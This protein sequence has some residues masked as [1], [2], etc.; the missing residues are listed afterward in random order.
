MSRKIVLVYDDDRKVEYVGNYSSI[1]IG[2]DLYYNIPSED[3]YGGK[4]DL[5]GVKKIHIDDVY[6]ILDVNREIA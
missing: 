5:T 2:I 3:I 6:I 1:A 4:L